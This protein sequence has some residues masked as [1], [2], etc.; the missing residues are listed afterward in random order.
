MAKDGGGVRL[1]VRFVRF[2][3]SF[4]GMTNNARQGLDL[5]NA[6]VQDA[7]QKRKDA[8]GLKLKARCCVWIEFFPSPYR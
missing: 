7:K 1:E 6:P 3:L 2:A 4:T 8:G 5:I